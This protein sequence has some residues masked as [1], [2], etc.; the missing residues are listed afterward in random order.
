M[1][2]SCP[3][4]MHHFTDSKRY[5]TESSTTILRE[6]L[7]QDVRE[8]VVAFVSKAGLAHHVLGNTEFRAGF[9]CNPTGRTQNRDELHKVSQYTKRVH[10]TVFKP[11][12][13]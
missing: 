12:Y 9:V 4:A 3:E 7:Q 13:L 2:R 11:P 1:S 5:T 10:H 8:K 6:L